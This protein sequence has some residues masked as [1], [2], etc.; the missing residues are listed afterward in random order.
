MKYIIAGT[1]PFASVSYHPFLTGSG[2]ARLADLNLLDSRDGI[3]DLEIGLSAFHQ[4]SHYWGVPLCNPHRDKPV[5]I[6][7]GSIWWA[8]DASTVGILGAIATIVAVVIAHLLNQRAG[9]RRANQVRD[10]VLKRIDDVNT[11][12]T[13]VNVA[14]SNRISESKTDLNARISE[15]RVEMSSQ[16]GQLRT[17]ITSTSTGIKEF[18]ASELRAVKAE[19]L[20]ALPPRA[21]SVSSS[22]HQK[23]I[24][25]FSLA[26]RMHL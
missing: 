12:V 18:M 8:M 16:A 26:F 1:F 5:L 4:R 13:E 22:E 24:C 7:V 25:P 2:S 17:E 23:I 21:R 3:V 15:V 19:I 10:E 14:L 20:A 6:R 11:R 9:E